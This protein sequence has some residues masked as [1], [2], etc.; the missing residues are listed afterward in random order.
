MKLA[1][2]IG[3]AR[4]I[5]LSDV[6]AHPLHGLQIGCIFQAFGDRQRAEIVRQIDDRL[7]DAGVLGSEPLSLTK[8]RSSLSSANGRSRSRAN[9]ENPSPKSSI[10]NVMP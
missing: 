7:A 10:A 8:L 3:R 9:E 5:A 2:G 1:F 4:K 6:A